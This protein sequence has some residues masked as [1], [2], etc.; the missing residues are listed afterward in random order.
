MSLQDYNLDEMQNA[1]PS[2]FDA[3]N[4]DVKTAI[5]VLRSEADKLNPSWDKKNLKTSADWLENEVL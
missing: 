4:E 5:N 1:S 2:I 3:Q